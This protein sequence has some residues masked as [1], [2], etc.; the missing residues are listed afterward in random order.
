MNKVEEAKREVSENFDFFQTQVIELK[1]NHFKQFALLYKKE[2]IEF[3]DSEDDAIKVGMKDYGEGEFS[4]QE[5]N[6]EVIDL[7]YQSNVLI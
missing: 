5:V 7:G 1:K 4:V 3:F 6:D 2:I